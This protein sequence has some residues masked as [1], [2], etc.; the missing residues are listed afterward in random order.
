[1]QPLRRQNH[2]ENKG[3]ADERE[4]QLSFDECG[5]IRKLL[6]MMRRLDVLR[7]AFLAFLANSMRYDL[8]RA[9]ANHLF[10]PCTDNFHAIQSV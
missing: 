10:A 5:P 9:I 4:E 6:G 7:H 3:E 2:K 8:L 1:M